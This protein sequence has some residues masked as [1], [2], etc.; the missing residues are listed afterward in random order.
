M[1]GICKLESKSNLE[2]SFGSFINRLDLDGKRA[3]RGD[4]E[5]ALTI[6]K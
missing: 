2:K 3:A 5:I 1:I 4:G 6:K